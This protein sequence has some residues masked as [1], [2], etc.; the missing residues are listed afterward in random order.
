MT[1]P[2][3]DLYRLSLAVQA[4]LACSLDPDHPDEHRASTPTGDV[5]WYRRRAA[6]GEVPDLP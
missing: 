6:H 5:Y 2:C 1:D 4:P 3:G